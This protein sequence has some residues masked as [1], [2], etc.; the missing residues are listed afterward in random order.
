MKSEPSV[1]PSLL[2][3]PGKTDSRRADPAFTLVELIVVITIIVVLV[4]L[5]MPA[6]NGIVGRANSIK[7]VSNLRQIGTGMAL[8]VTDHDGRLPGPLSGAQYAMYFALSPGNGRLS[9]YLQGYISPDIPASGGNMISPLFVCP[10]F[11]RVIKIDGSAQPYAMNNPTMP[12]SNSSGVQNR[13]WGTG[14]G[15]ADPTPGAVIASLSGALSGGKTPLSE[16]WAMQDLDKDW[17]NN[18]GTAPLHPVHP[19]YK[20]VDHPAD[21]TSIQNAHKGSYRN[22]LFFDFHVGR[23][24]L[25][26]TVP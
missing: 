9:M 24:K 8:Y 7:C 11:A 25:D 14:A 10:S 21:A 17:N 22:A 15:G 4:L 16:I 18:F 3:V 5:T 12:G 26:S 19:T 13:V 6:I 1:A 2:R 20:A 23:L